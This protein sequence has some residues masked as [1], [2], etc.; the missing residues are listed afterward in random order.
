MRDPALTPNAYGANGKRHETAI[1]RYG[2]LRSAPLERDANR[3]TGIET[4]RDCHAAVRPN[5]KNNET[6]NKREKLRSS[7]SRRER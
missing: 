7:L 5:K 2:A 1:A 6:E 3:P 4:A